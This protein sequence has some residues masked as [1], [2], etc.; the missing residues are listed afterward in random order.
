MKSKGILGEARS[1]YETRHDYSAFGFTPSG[2]PS[3]AQAFNILLQYVV[4]RG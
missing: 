3:Q 1:G 4:E 2:P